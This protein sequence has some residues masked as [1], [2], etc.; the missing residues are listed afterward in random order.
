MFMSNPPGGA[1]ASSFTWYI[2]Y[3][4]VSLQSVL[5]YLVFYLVEATNK[6]PHLFVRETSNQRAVNMLLG[7][8]PS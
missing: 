5:E 1:V 2:C 6:Q 4:A 3:I 7:L 8:I